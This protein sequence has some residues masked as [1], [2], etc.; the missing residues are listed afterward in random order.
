MKFILTTAGI[1]SLTLMSSC[2]QMSQQAA[3]PIPP[4]APETLRRPIPPGLQHYYTLPAPMKR[5]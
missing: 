4:P 2:I 5:Y 3:G 1:L